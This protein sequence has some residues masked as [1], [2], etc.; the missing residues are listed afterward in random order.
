M[1]KTSRLLIRPFEDTDAPF[2]VRLLN[3]DAFLKYIGDK[4]VRN[5]GQAISYL[6]KG[7][8]ACYN[9][10]G[11]SLQAVVL[12]E[13]SEAIGMCG[14]LKRDY[15][16]APDIGFA[17]LEEFCKEGYGYESAEAVLRANAAF[18]HI[19]AITSPENIAS[20]KLLLKLG[21]EYKTKLPVE[22]DNSE[23]KLFTKMQH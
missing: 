7:P 12:K 22:P 3:E 17:F 9:E 2:L 8:R 14:L 4:N 20:E 11:F 23:V 1:L 15:L 18:K 19:H 13:T 10:H 6:E 21:F 5:E 16:D